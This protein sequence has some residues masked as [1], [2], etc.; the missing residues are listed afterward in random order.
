MANLTSLNATDIVKVSV[1]LKIARR[2]RLEA[3]RIAKA[4]RAPL[5]SERDAKNKYHANHIYIESPKITKN[6]IQINLS[7]TPVAAAFEWGGEPHPISARNVPRLIFDG[8]N[9]WKGQKIWWKKTINHPGIRIR[10]PFLEPAK[11]N[12]RQENL[13]DLR[14]EAV[15]NIRL[16]VKGMARVVK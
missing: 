11:K 14:K 15:G 16:I 5:A 4:K 13:E 1:L 7:I 8:T 2:I 12:T 6:Q 9:A 10:K 3:A